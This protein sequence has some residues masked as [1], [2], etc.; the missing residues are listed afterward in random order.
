MGL[1]ALTPLEPSDRQ[2]YS[3]EDDEEEELDGE[4]LSK[5]ALYPPLTSSSEPFH[6]PDSLPTRRQLRPG[7]SDLQPMMDLLDEVERSCLG[8]SEASVRTSV[9]ASVDRSVYL[10][11]MG[12]HVRI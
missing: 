8:K 11:V 5:E 3:S 10:S 7:P 6:G 4:G 9:R 2:M 12:V 1:P